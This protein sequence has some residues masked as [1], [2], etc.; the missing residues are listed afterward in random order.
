MNDDT[1]VLMIY[2]TYQYDDTLVLIIYLYIDCTICGF[3]YGFLAK[4]AAGS[5]P[6]SVRCV[7]I[8]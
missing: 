3:S 7:H 2:L 4:L 8:E 1:L 6:Y 5:A